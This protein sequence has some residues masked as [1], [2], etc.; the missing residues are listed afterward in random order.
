MKAIDCHCRGNWRRQSRKNSL[1]VQCLSPSRTYAGYARL[2]NTRCVGVATAEEGVGACAPV[3][4]EVKPVL[5]FSHEAA[6]VSEASINS[7]K[8]NE[9]VSSHAPSAGHACIW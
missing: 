9:P 4:F 8:F 1:H 7:Q 6:A 5:H 3:R 2:G